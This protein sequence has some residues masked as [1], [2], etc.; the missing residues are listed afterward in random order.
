MHNEP[1]SVTAPQVLVKQPGETRNF[2]MDFSSLLAASETISSPSVSYS[3]SGLTI[4]VA[5]VSGN[6]AIFDISGGT[7]PVKYRLEVT[8]TTSGGSVLVG[9]GLLRVYD[10]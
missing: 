1:S 8:V 6:K 4:G 7:H 10:K 5:S 9:D 3:P 2:S